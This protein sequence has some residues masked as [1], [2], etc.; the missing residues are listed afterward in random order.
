MHNQ[1]EDFTGGK[2]W[3]VPG[4]LYTLSEIITS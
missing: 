3:K 4:M 2:R 1:P